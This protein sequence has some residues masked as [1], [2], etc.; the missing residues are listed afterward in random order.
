MDY[1]GFQ[2]VRHVKDIVRTKRL[3]SGVLNATLDLG[4]RKIGDLADWVDDQMAEVEKRMHE[5][6]DSPAA[7]KLQKENVNKHALVDSCQKEEPSPVD[8]AIDWIR[9]RLSQA[10]KK[11]LQKAKRPKTR[12]TTLVQ[13]GEAVASSIWDMLSHA[14]ENIEEILL[15]V[16]I[17]VL[18]IFSKKRDQSITIAELFQ[19]ALADIV[20]GLVKTTGKLVS[21]VIRMVAT[22]LMELRNILN[23]PL[24]VLIFGSLMQDWLGIGLPSVMDT[25]CFMVA[26]PA[27]IIRKI[28]SAGDSEKKKNI[29][30]LPNNFTDK[31]VEDA[32]T[33]KLAKEKPAQASAW[34]AMIYDIQVAVVPLMAIIDVGQIGYAALT[35]GNGIRGVP[36]VK[37]VGGGGKFL[38]KLLVL[39]ASVPWD[40]NMPA[41]EHR[42]FVSLSVLIP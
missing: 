11:Q 5:A 2:L 19:Q 3:I 9:D 23:T 30:G 4:V 27:T 36:A 25:V 42:A 15:K 12:D 32:F 33:G 38:L 31:E 14:F 21:D 34:A 20:I 40:S 41:R 35:A 22:V 7:A 8:I 37:K 13:S 29:R 6:L 39:T 18:S 10:A 24:D 28:A 17:S 26:V 1:L 16:L